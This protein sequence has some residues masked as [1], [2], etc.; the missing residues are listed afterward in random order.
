M[1]VKALWMMLCLVAA[2]TAAAWD[3]GDVSKSR[4]WVFADNTGEVVGEKVAGARSKLV[5]TPEGACVSIDTSGLLPGA[6]TVWMRAFNDPA[7]CPFGE[8]V[9]GSQCS[10]LGIFS[11]TCI[12]DGTCSVFWV[13][14]GTIGPDGVGHFSACVEKDVPPGFVILGPGLTD[15]LTAEIHLVL[16]HHGDAPVGFA[17]PQENERLGRQLTRLN[18][19]CEGDVG[20]EF[21]NFDDPD[22][23]PNNCFDQQIAL[24]P[25]GD[26]DS[27]SDS[28]S[29]SD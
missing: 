29:D 25:A 15:P 5:R 3:G 2:G 6:Y 17:D 26:A 14:N 18:G 21:D 10:R 22:V 1:R 28:D 7:G 13:G 19:N 9:G 12:P 16:K 11:S 4:L 27:D 20:D 23:V 24:H 8:G